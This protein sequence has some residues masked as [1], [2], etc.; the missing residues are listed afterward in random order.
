MSVHPKAAL[1]TVDINACTSG[2]PAPTSSYSETS[3]KDRGRRELTHQKSVGCHIL[4]ITPN[5]I[6]RQQISDSLAHLQYQLI[7]V[8]STE[9]A[10]TAISNQTMDLILIDLKAPSMGAVAF[11]ELIRKNPATR[12][13]PVFIQA[14]ED[15]GDAEPRAFAAGTDE[16]LIGP[17]KSTALRAHVQ[18]TLSLKSLMESQN[19]SESLLLALAK[20]VE[21][22]DPDLGQHCQRLAF[23]SS[24]MGFALGLPPQDVRSL[25]RAGYLHDIGKLGIPER[26]LFKTGPLSTQEWTIMRSHSERGE[27]LCACM[28]SMASVLPIIRHHHERFDGS[29]YPDGL[30]GEQIPLL[31]RILQTVDIYDALTTERPYKRAFSP[32]EA[33]VIMREETKKGWR[34]PFLVEVFADL[35]PLFRQSTQVD[36]ARLS[37]QALG[38]SLGKYRKNSPHMPGA[39][40]RDSL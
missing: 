14:T 19:D 37:L 24:A 25:E 28:T 21:D 1:N 5:R 34:D 9:D 32:D 26:V 3:A 29:G 18:A 27:R 35:L 6:N 15:D 30:K 4:I 11:C 16:F 39:T 22:R 13:V 23:M 12:L 7:E 2:S 40:S 36:N 20:S 10:L 31:A 33:L 8:D 17:L 38:D